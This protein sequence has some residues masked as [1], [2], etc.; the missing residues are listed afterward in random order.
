MAI[1]GGCLVFTDAKILTTLFAVFLYH[2]SLFG[3]TAG[4]H[5]LW[6][7]KAYKAK[8]PFRII[9]AV[10]NSIS[11]QNS[12]YEWGRDHRVHHKYTET[13]ADPVNSL[14]GFFFSHC[15][16]LMCRKHPDVKGI[17]GKVDLS[18]MLADPVVAI[19]KQYYMPS[20]VLLCFVMPTVVPTYFWSESLWN[21]FFVCVM[22]RY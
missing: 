17:G 22:F 18:D 8:L 9:L 3:I 1:Y 10:C 4:V 12:I 14:R 7:H 2:I 15:G 6:S 21:A 11:Y 16:W 13:N 20:V 19:Q 5:R